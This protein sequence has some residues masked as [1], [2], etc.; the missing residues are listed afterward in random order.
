MGPSSPSSL[1]PSILHWAFLPFLNKVQLVLYVRLI[2]LIDGMKDPCRSWKQF[3]T[4]I[5][6]RKITRNV[7]IFKRFLNSD[8]VYC[9]HFN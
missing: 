3:E 5:L 4:V 9:Q 2:K 6:I 7:M 1:P 8:P